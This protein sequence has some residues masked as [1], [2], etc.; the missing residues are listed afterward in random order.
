MFWRWVLLT[1]DPTKQEE[2]ATPSMALIAITYNLEKYSMLEKLVRASSFLVFSCALVLSAGEVSAQTIDDSTGG[3]G[4]SGPVGVNPP[5]SIE[6]NSPG[7][8]DLSTGAYSSQDN[9]LSIGGGSLASGGISLVRSYNS[10]VGEDFASLSGFRA[11]GWSHNWAMS[12][13]QSTVPR[14]YYNIGTDPVCPTGDPFCVTQTDEFYSVVSFG[15]SSAKFTNGLS[16]NASAQNI[17]GVYE[18]LEPQNLTQKL[19]FVPVA[20]STN[21]H[22]DGHFELTDADG[23]QYIFGAANAAPGPVVRSVIAPNGRR[24][25][26]TYQNSAVKSVF[27]SDGFGLIFEF[28]STLGQ[29]RISKACVVNLAHHDLGPTS[30]CPTS[31]Q[32]VSYSYGEVTVSYPAIQQRPAMTFQRP[33]LFT[34][35]NALSQTVTY[36]YDDGQHVV[37]MKQH[38]QS[39]CQMQLTYNQCDY[40]SELQTAG[41]LPAT[42]PELHLSEA[43]LTQTYATGEQLTY[44]GWG[45]N[46]YCP[47]DPAAGF[48]LQGGFLDSD[49]NTTTVTMSDNKPASIVDPLNRTTTQTYWKPANMA[50]IPGVTGDGLLDET[51]YPEGNKVELEY[52][53]RGNLVLSRSVPKSGSGSSALT[54]S[55][56]FPGSCTT[57]NRKTCNKPT[58]VTDANGNTSNFEY[59][60]TH[61]GMTRS[62]APAVGGIRPETRYEY[63]QKY[64]WVKNSGSGYS[65][66]ASPIWVLTS[67]YTC[68]TSAMDSSGNCAAGSA[69]KVTTT[70][71]YE[72]GSS[73]RGSNLLMLGTAVTADGQTLRTCMTYDDQGRRISETQPKANLASCQ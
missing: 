40:R 49:G 64:A 68:R 56:G 70:Y 3:G 25:D 55:A 8:V 69:D 19:E 72:Q 62:R 18:A 14:D 24:A 2:A 57:S 31:A 28:S 51:V 21:Q 63:A 12:V 53:A 7:G 36:E 66:A 52:N 9:D 4:S 67:E 37:C 59:S 32:S 61:G 1:M 60:T 27:T 16:G 39:T 65:Q 13:R 20:G 50:S 38:G 48:G 11:R 71:E 15:G 22:S 54:M 6:T 34:V 42:L 29:Q 41:E 5:P 23:T 10:S 33:Q 17:P 26:L 73:S 47:A 58:S 46:A 35:T 43:V 44:N 45:A 30:D